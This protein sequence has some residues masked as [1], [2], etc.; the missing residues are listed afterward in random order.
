MLGETTRVAHPL[1]F[2]RLLNDIK[3]MRNVEDRLEA[4]ERSM[5]SLDMEWSETYDKMRVMMM[6][7]AKRAERLE[8]EQPD[9]AP[10][11]PESGEA[12]TSLSGRQHEINQRILARRNRFQ[13]Q[14]PS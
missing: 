2:F 8:H 13:M 6:K 5:K 9:S 3:K 1:M 12:T 11:S 10:A 7:I 4:L 14:R